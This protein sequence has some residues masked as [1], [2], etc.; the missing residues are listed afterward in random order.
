MTF[1]KS[2]EWRTGGAK[3][4]GWS[5]SGD[6]GGGGGGDRGGGVGRIKGGV[7]E[8]WLLTEREEVQLQKHTGCCLAI[9]RYG[10]RPG[11]GETVQKMQ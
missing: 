8:G 7:V 5:G 4:W 1:L 6:G 3:K 10:C 11:R 2:T 9:T